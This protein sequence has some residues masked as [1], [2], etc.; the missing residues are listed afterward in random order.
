[1]DMT[2]LMFGVGAVGF[3]AAA[4]LYALGAVLVYSSRSEKGEGQWL[5]IALI[6]SSVWACYV[7]LALFMPGAWSQWLIVADA[8]HA[9]IWVGFAASMLS[10]GRRLLPA[11]RIGH[12]LLA[13]ALIAVGVVVYTSLAESG[14]PSAARLPQLG[15]GAMLL[16]PLLGVLA[17][18]QVFRNTDFEH[19]GALRPLSIA[20]GI[21]FAVDIFIYS[22]AVL[23]SG[24]DGNLWLLRGVANAVAAPAIVVAAKRQPIWSRDLFVSRHV[25]FYTAS[26]VAAGVYLLAVAGGGYLI[27]SQNRSWGAPLQMLFLLSA[28]GVMFYALFSVRIH[29]RLKIFIAKHFYRNRYDYREEWLRF[30]STLSGH[31]DVASLPERGVKALA[32]IIGASHGELWLSSGPGAP[33][34][35]YGSLKLPVP[36]GELMREDVLPKFL[37]DTKWIV[38]SQEY[39]RDP[40]L[41]EHAFVGDRRLLDTPSIVVP[42]LHGDDLIGIVRLDRPRSLGK[43]T[44]EDHDLLR[45][46]G[47]QVAIFLA[48]EMA[49][50]ELAESRQFEAFS[51]LTAF[52]MHDLKNLVAQQELLVRNAQRFRHRPEFIDDAFSTIEVGVERM[53]KVIELLGGAAKRGQLARIDARQVLRN[54]A[55]TCSDRSP[56]PSIEE[57]IP[58]VFIEIDKDRLTMALTH[59]V[60]NAQDATPEDGQIRLRLLDRDGYAHIEVEDTGEGMDPEFVRHRLFKAFD[61]TKGV[62]GMG[63]G[64]YQ[65]QD[66]ARDA[67]GDVDVVSDI[68]KGTLL[69]L[70]LPLAEPVSA[71]MG[72]SFG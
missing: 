28:A 40:E 55:E 32:D 12:A 51:K 58:E 19:R 46:A 66:V 70:R 4:L 60:R 54:V 44:Y 48:Q 34:V 64:A 13:G 8:L 23:F 27:S 24:V 62:E 56:S 69:R 5:V 11:H 2:S 68:G 37:S 25:V 38:D 36:H 61:S 65:I 57:P 31:S 29:T 9:A 30:I 3:A 72:R 18:E 17:L 22:Q 14:D 71:Q 59:A 43:L 26:L 50:N 45:T 63:I 67:G 21:I 42:L 53:R 10:G 20:V 15:L 52:L 49:Q 39:V 6:A 7:L 1:M 33:F 35:G 41:Y 16:L 47:R